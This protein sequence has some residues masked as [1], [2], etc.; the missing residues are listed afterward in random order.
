MAKP[1]KKAD[2]QSATNPWRK[3]TAKE[4][5]LI[6]KDETTFAEYLATLSVEQIDAY[7]LLLQSNRE[8]DASSRESFIALLQNVRKEREQSDR[9]IAMALSPLVTSA[10]TI[11]KLDEQ[12]DALE[13]IA[14]EL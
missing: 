14:K 6:L 13:R 9:Q 10:E 7:L 8:M 5:E 2:G 3:L 12:I 4:V 1:P 11:H